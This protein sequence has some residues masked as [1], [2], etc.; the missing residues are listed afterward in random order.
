MRWSVNDSARQI[1]SGM[2]SGSFNSQWSSHRLHL[3]PL[4]HALS[5]PG[6]VPAIQDSSDEKQAVQRITP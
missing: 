1:N 3:S 2:D 6:G 5:N 4:I